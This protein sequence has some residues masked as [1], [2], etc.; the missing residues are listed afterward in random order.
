MN[1]TDIL[2]RCEGCGAVH[3]TH[4]LLG[5][6]PETIHERVSP[7]EPMPYGECPDCGS[8]CHA[9]QPSEE[10][11]RCVTLSSTLGAEMA[12]RW[13]PVAARVLARCWKHVVYEVAQRVSPLSNFDAAPAVAALED[14]GLL[15]MTTLD[16]ERIA[17]ENGMTLRYEVREVQGERQRAVGGWVVEAPRP[18]TRDQIE[19]TGHEEP[20]FKYEEVVF[21]PSFFGVLHVAMMRSIDDWISEVI[22]CAHRD[23][24]ASDVGQKHGSP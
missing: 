24:A 19:A 20:A 5:I 8:V 21:S 11:G 2:M 12:R 4:R 1:T 13:R 18:V 16:G 6:P 14:E 22:D 15:Q 9:F 23:T 3:P 7:G 17:L 10:T